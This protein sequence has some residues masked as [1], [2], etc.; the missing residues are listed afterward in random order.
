LQKY[1]FEE[2]TGFKEK[3]TQQSKLKVAEKEILFMTGNY[4]SVCKVQSEKSAH[5]HMYY[6]YYGAWDILIFM[7]LGMALYKNGVLLG[8][9]A[10]KLY[11]LLCIGG[12]ALGYCCPISEWSKSFNTN[13]TNLNL[14]KTFPL[15][16]ISW[17]GH[18][19]QLDSLGL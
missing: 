4:T 9:A 11:W 5:V 19:V 2:M 7:F 15:I 10:A 6:I 8:N 16:C 17:P 18:C 12:L 14:S 1:E 13:S 3:S